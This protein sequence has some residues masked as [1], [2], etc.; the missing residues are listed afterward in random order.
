MAE[1]ERRELLPGPVVHADL[2]AAAALAAPHQQRSAARI[3]VG[4]GKRERLA[5]PQAGAPE[6]DDQAA[7]PAAVDTVAGQLTPP[8]GEVATT[9]LETSAKLTT[10]PNVNSS[11]PMEMLAKWTPP[12]RLK[13]T[14]GSPPCPGVPLGRGPGARR[15]HSSPP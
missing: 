14:T 2:A 6:H 7:Q 3:E 1:N 12:S 11:M 13:A 9:M 4:L 8:S 10:G 5:D 15:A